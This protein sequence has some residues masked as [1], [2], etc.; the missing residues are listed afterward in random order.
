MFNCAL[1]RA[2]DISNC[3]PWNYVRTPSHD[4]NEI[5]LCT[6]NMTRLFQETINGNK[7]QSN[8]IFICG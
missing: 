6:R 8:I 4:L 1:M 5:Q 3:V 2:Q 7:Y